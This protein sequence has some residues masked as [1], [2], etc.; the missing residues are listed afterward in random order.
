MTMVKGS[1]LVKVENME[2]SNIP[3]DSRDQAV[4]DFHR[5]KTDAERKHD[6]FYALSEL[7]SHQFSY[8]DFYKGLLY[9]SWPEFHANQILGS[10]SQK[11]YQLIQSFSQC[12]QLLTLDSENDFKQKE[13]PQAYTGYCNPKEYVEFVGNMPTWEEWHRKWYTTHPQEID[14]KG[15]ANDWLPRLDLILD[16]LKR[17]LQTMFVEKGFTH[18]EA[19]QKVN[20]IADDNIVHEF[21]DQVMK[22]KGDTLEGYASQIGGEICRSNYYTFEKELSSLEQQKAGSLREIYS[23]VN[24]NGQ[25]QFISIDFAHGMFEFLDVNGHHV[26]EFRFDGS[27]NSPAEV[28]HGLKCLE[29]W[30]KRWGGK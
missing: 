2:L 21:H 28:D 17:E 1:L 30:R 19:K 7:F 15:M 8:G 4:C 16:I 14:W 11:T 25:E 23:I 12:I 10:I 3:A 18:K 22:H 6:C 26:G 9:R 13:F 24:K 29:H 20:A 5:M 27:L